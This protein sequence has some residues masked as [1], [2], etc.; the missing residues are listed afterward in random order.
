M[1]VVTGGFDSD[2]SPTIKI[3][4]RDS[5]DGAQQEFDAVI[6]SGFTG[7]LSMPLVHAL[8]LGLK[9]FGTTSLT[10]A[11]GSNRIN[12]VATGY[13]C[14]G[15]NEARGTVI[16]QTDSTEFLVGMDF[17]R[18]LGPMLIIHHDQFVALVSGNEVSAIAAT[19]KGVSPL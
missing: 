12:L 16:L 14:V 18:A 10:L 1:P 19:A 2:G 13:V 17:I 5:T 15:P 11:D 7:F 4:V 8:P 9:L 3:K 6:D